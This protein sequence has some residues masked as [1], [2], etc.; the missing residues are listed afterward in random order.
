[1]PKQAQ[2]ITMIEAGVDSRSAVSTAMT[3]MVLVSFR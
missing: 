1:L 3:V 2:L